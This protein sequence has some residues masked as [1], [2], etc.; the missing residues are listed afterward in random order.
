M[1]IEDQHLERLRREN[2]N[3]R[4]ERR[5]D[6][7][8]VIIVP[9]VPLPAPIWNKAQATV[10][11]ITPVGYPAAKPDCFWVDADLRLKSGGIP[12]NANIQVPPFGGEPRL[13][14][15]WHTSSW[16][17]NRDNL[18]TYLQVVLD[19]LRRAE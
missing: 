13:W 9:D 19:R 6:G 16:N 10:L 14:F 4:L 1:T 15:S 11:F 17:A 12:K 5:P 7:S 8:T 3:A 2:P 18:T